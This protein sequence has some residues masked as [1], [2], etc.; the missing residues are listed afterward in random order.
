MD[1]GQGSARKLWSDAV[2]EM[3][4]QTQTKR[5]GDESRQERLMKV[6]YADRRKCVL[7]IKAGW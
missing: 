2:S 5:E 1:G 6:W 7:N 3:E 4:G